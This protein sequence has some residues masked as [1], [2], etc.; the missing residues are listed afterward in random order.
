MI[1]LASSCTNCSLKGGD[2]HVNATTVDAGFKWFKTAV[3]RKARSRKKFTNARSRREEIK[4]IITTVML[5]NFNR[6]ILRLSWLFNHK[7]K[8]TD[9]SRC[10]KKES[11]LETLLWKYLQKKQRKSTL[12]RCEIDWSQVRIDKILSLLLIFSKYIA[13]TPDSRLQKWTA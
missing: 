2:L 5:N 12:H 4:W 9:G 3:K 8:S 11:S 13:K 7:I 6:K 10:T 1:S